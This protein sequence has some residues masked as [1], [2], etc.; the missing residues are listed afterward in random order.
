MR[1][2]IRFAAW[3]YPR[4]W[5]ERYGVEFDA[6]LE[7]VRPGWRE[8]ASVLKGA[9]GMQ[10]THFG[11]MAACFAVAGAIVAGLVSW[12]MPNQYISTA[13]VNFSPAEAMKEEIPALVVRSTSRSSL[14]AIL[15]KHNLYDRELTEKPL[16]ELIERMRLRIRIHPVGD[17]AFSVA[18]RD[19][20]P[21]TARR[22]TQD[23][24]SGLMASNVAGLTLNVLDPANLPTRPSSPNRVTIYG[25]GIAIGALT[26]AVVAW[27]RRAPR[28]RMA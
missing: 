23:L 28:P 27:F 12:R 8:F 15:K 10:I 26:G 3:L 16:E 19:H 11:A 2:L 9:L 5:R 7:D 13:T 21:A 18:F 22:V 1:N 6:L 17:A 25:T 24:L 4:R 20:D 14:V